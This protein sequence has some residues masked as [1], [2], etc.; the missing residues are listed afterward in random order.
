M[1]T[2][3][4][5]YDRLFQLLV[6]HDFGIKAPAVM[7]RLRIVLGIDGESRLLGIAEVH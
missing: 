4:L 3:S 7:L 6:S 2:N 5:Y 1:H